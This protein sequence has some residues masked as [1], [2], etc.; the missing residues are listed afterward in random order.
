MNEVNPA[1]PP[2]LLAAALVVS[3]ALWQAFV[4][5]DL[6]M[7]TALTR[8]LLAVVA[9]WVVLSVAISLL[10]ERKPAHREKDSAAEPTPVPVNPGGP[11]TS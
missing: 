11:T 10:P 1:S 2:V 6:P 9:S 3:P 7:G 8:F 5:G 4:V